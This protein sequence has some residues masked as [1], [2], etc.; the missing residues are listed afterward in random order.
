MH[1]V[2]TANPKNDCLR[3]EHVR[4]RRLF[5]PTRVSS[6]LL[7]LDGCT[8]HRV[9]GAIDRTMIVVQKRIADR[10]WRPV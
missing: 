5:R 3:L 9:A 6:A 8:H 10:K 7:P 1:L 2:G 4:V